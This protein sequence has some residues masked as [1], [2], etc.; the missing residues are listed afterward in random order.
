MCETEDSI[1]I[2][3]FRKAEFLPVPILLLEKR[4]WTVGEYLLGIVFPHLSD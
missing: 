1:N 4:G 3:V 2:S